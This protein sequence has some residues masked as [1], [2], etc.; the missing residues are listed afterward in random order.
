MTAAF[1]T[2]NMVRGQT[3]LL[4]ALRREKVKV[5]GEINAV[6]AIPRINHGNHTLFSYL[7][8]LGTDRKD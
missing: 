6:D 3:F 5:A 7:G 8:V 2:T 4:K 1:I